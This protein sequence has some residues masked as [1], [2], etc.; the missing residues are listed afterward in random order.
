LP[1]QAKRK[2]TKVV[3][4]QFDKLTKSIVQ[5]VT[6]RAALKKFGIGHLPSADADGDGY[7]DPGTAPVLT[8]PTLDNAKR[9]PIL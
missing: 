9:V 5:S 2:E 4:N 6:R 7:P 1:K 8:V 3:Q